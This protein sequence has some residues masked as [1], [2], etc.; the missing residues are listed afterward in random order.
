MD[1]LENNKLEK[2]LQLLLEMRRQFI[3]IIELYSVK[4][5]TV[6]KQ[7]PL[8][9]SLRFL[10]KNIQKDVDYKNNIKNYESEFIY[11]FRLFDEAGFHEKFEESSNKIRKVYQEFRKL[12]K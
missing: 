2:L 5:K 11:F 4:D 10:I 1:K 7:S 3:L 8:Y 6:I 12:T 9:S